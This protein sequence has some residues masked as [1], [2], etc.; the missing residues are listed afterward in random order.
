MNRGYKIAFVAASLA[1]GACATMSAASRIE[2]QLVA[3]GISDPRAECLAEELRDNLDRG[4]LN[5]VADFLEGVNRAQSPGGALDALLR[6]DNPRAAA[7]IAS[8]GIVC[9]FE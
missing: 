3:L 2:K 1:A 4:D 5:D 8:A 9:A 6:I 7:A